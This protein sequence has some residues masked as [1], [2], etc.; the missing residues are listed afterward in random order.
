MGPRPRL[1][2]HRNDGRYRRRRGDCGRYG[3][4]RW[5][6]GRYRRRRGQLLLLLEVGARFGRWGGGRRAL[7]QA[8]VWASMAVSACV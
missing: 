5:R 1:V 7:V 3:R 4:W 6:H 2:G 8:A